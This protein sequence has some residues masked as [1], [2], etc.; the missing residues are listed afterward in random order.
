MNKYQKEFNKLVKWDIRFQK[1]FQIPESTSWYN[2]KKLV[3]S[4]LELVY[5]KPI[6]KI[7]LDN[8]ISLKHIFNV[9]LL[10]KMVS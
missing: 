9:L 4:S 2:S 10:T 6:S 3:K 1:E 5:E 7:T 8:I